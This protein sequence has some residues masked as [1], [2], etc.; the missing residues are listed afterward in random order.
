LNE[1]KTLS[2]E[3]VL[4]LLKRFR[5]IDI[6]IAIRVYCGNALVPRPSIDVLRSIEARLFWLA[7]FTSHVQSFSHSGLLLRDDVTLEDCL[8]DGDLIS[9][10]MGQPIT[11]LLGDG[12]F[13]CDCYSEQ[14]ARASHIEENHNA[15]FVYRSDAQLLYLHRW[16][17]IEQSLGV[18]LRRWMRSPRFSFPPE[19][20]SVFKLFFDEQAIASNPWQAIACF[21][22]LSHQLTIISG[23][24]GTGK[25][26]TVTRLVGLLLSLPFDQQPQ[27]I[28]LVAPTGKA[29]DRLRESFSNNFEQLLN[30]LPTDFAS[31]L[32]LNI[33]NRLQKSATIHSFLGSRG[34]HGFSYNKEHLVGCDC[35]IVDE[36]TMVD[37]ELFLALLR[38]LPEKCR[39]I[40]LGDKNQLA[41]VETGNVF[42]DL[43]TAAESSGGTLNVFTSDFR[44]L[45]TDFSG[46]ELESRGKLLPLMKDTVVELE[47]SY[48]FSKGSE[49][50][51]LA[52]LLLEEGRMPRAGEFD[53]KMVSFDGKWKD[54][55][56]HSIEG[57]RRCFKDGG[58]PEVLLNELNRTRV[59]CAVRNG[60]LGVGAVNQ[61]LTERVLGV[62]VDATSVV[63]GLPFVVRANDKNL[64]V[65]NGDCGVF[66]R[67]ASGSLAAYLPAEVP[68][69]ELRR[70]HSY[71][72][73]HWEAAFAI[74][75]HSSQGSE[76]TSVTVILP[77]TR[78][79]FVSWELVYTAITRG[80][81]S[82][83]LVLP[84][85]LLGRSLPRTRRVSGLVHELK[86]GV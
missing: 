55:I 61:L 10:E 51:C 27:R 19:F 17:A 38:A 2:S 29:A 59:L 21:T 6:S 1:L 72:L 66:F 46:V 31:S 45:F 39:V 37:M 4:I 54:S 56:R 82:V 22:A 52:R 14:V 77:E 85:D 16:F 64:G 58:G 8:S 12:S 65:W 69:G 86:G 53:L 43:T 42:S 18:L 33:E 44:G 35:L 67:D 7:A 20:G 5:P 15:F 57:Y 40:L 28:A 60:P 13:V 30:T 84:A 49:V 9:V 80:K 83:G 26:T 75:I 79:S 41:A 81:E 3:L 78:E 74:T 70:I 63:H 32:R 36:S 25:T 34:A 47:Y 62:G 23:G 76:Y 73:P 48:R 71:A 50:G 68:G 11:D 24:P